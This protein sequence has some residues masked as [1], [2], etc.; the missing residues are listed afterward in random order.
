MSK[1]KDGQERGK[2][3]LETAFQPRVISPGSWGKTVMPSLARPA[4]ASVWS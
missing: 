3:T 4:L 2:Y 1:R